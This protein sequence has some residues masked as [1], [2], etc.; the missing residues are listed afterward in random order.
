MSR[1]KCSREQAREASELV[2]LKSE[3]M[4]EIDFFSKKFSF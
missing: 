4:G 1:F 2:G 3:F